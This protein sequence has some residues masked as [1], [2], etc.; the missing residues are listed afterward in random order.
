MDLESLFL[1]FEILQN[2]ERSI[3]SVMAKLDYLWDNSSIVQIYQGKN[4]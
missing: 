2:T 4:V 3:Y 1:S